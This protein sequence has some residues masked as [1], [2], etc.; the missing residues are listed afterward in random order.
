MDVRLHDILK[1]L[2]P[3]LKKV[4]E[5]IEK[6]IKTGV[7]II[8]ESAFHLFK[9]GGKRIRA[10]MVLLTG[11]MKGAMPSGIEAIAAA[12]EIVHAASLIH[13]DIIDHAEK[14]RGVPAVAKQWG[15]R[16][17]VLSGDYM[18]TIALRT[19]LDDGNPALLPLMIDGTRDLVKGEL[20]Q[21]QYSSIDMINEEHYF[22]IIELKTAR[23]M[24]A[25]AKLGALKAGFH[26][27]ECA[28]IYEFGLNLGY[29]FQIID[30]ILDLIEE[31]ETGKEIG[32][33]LR[34]GKIT[35]PIL[36]MM[37]NSGI[38]DRSSLK[39]ALKNSSLDIDAMKRELEASGAIEYSRRYAIGY[40]E[41]AK[42]L[43]SGFPET[44]CLR[45][46]IDLSDFFIY[47]NY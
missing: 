36:Y 20:C 1:P 15:A 45:I 23:F 9:S 24:A 38:F 14:R 25:C 42:S 40:I 43:I 8:D 26:E 37:N 32:N 41:K 3:Y 34:N 17:A 46:L 30:D 47:R 5:E 6:K 19:A 28:K 13:D 11:G 12:T 4:E 10:A 27:A 29:A 2:T 44:E 35:L 16:I 7:P 18:Y 22:K 33:D 31:G 21:L 39:N